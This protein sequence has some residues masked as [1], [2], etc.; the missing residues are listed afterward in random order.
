MKAGLHGN[1]LAYLY[2]KYIHGWF[3]PMGR[4][5]W[6]ME[7]LTGSICG[8]AVPIQSNTQSKG[9]LLIWHHGMRWV[10]MG[11]GVRHNVCLCIQ[12]LH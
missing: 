8:L 4:S 12:H 6:Q 10:V 3:A 11:T 1:V 5:Q 9:D 2:L 7:Y